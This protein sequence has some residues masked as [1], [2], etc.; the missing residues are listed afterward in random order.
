MNAISPVG[1]CP[2]ILPNAWRTTLHPNGRGDTDSENSTRQQQ[3]S[4]STNRGHQSIPTRIVYTSVTIDKFSGLRKMVSPT[5]LS[6][7][8]GD[9][10]ISVSPGN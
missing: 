7:G 4:A 8:S 6:S 1:R 5:I 3:L 2:R 10:D 9:F